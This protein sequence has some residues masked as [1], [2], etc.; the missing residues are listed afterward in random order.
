MF[1]YLRERKTLAASRTCPDQG[2]DL[3]PFGVWD[4]AL[5]S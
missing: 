1:I 3:Q 5:T 4:S 2:L